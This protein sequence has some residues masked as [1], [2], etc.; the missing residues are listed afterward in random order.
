M[1]RC[2]HRNKKLERKIF[3]NPLLLQNQEKSYFQERRK[4]MSLGRVTG[5]ARCFRGANI[6][7]SLALG[8]AYTTILLFLDI[9]GLLYLYVTYLFLPRK[10]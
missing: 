6:V 7:L 3:K 2:I 10:E 4:R 1:G 8:N 5:S 9:V